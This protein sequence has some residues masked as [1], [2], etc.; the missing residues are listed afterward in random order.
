M[1]ELISDI[2]NIFEFDIAA[3]ATNLVPSR[4]DPSLTFPVGADKRAKLLETCVLMVDIR[5]STKISQSLK[6]DKVQLGKI[7]SAF[8]Y[9]MAYVA[10]E[11]GYVRNIIG[12]RVMVVFEPDN[13]FK[14]AINC[15]AKMYNIALKILSPLIVNQYFKVGIGIDYGQMLVL[16]AG[17]R[18]KH[19]EMSEYK[20]LVWVGDAANIASKLCDCANKD[21]S[22]PLFEISYE[23]FNFKKTF[24]GFETTPQVNG[25]HNPKYSPDFEKKIDH[26][27]LDASAFSRYVKITNGNWRYKNNRVVNFEIQNRNGS[28][29]PI[30]LSKTVYDGFKVSDPESPYL[31]N[32]M[33]QTFPDNPIPAVYGGRL[34]VPDIQYLKK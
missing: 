27:S 24:I 25:L 30:L 21:Y 6:L 28:L 20:G 9:A 1:N 3:S 2:K 16:K 26:I 18:K 34:N 8:I 15:A 4:H 17:L 10:D 12:D 29:P 5:N 13:C 7:Y 19:E 11:Y 23:Y 22:S 31:V 33:Q 32:L 14:S